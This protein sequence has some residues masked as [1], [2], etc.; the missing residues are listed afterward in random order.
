M[1]DDKSTWV[2]IEGPGPGDAGFLGRWL[3]AAVAADQ[4][5]EQQ[6][7][8][9]TSLKDQ[10]VRL[11]VVYTVAFSPPA[12]F[13]VR[14]LM[15]NL[16]CFS[17]DLWDECGNLFVVMAMLGFFRHTGNRYQ[18]T[19]PEDISGSKIETALLKLAA[20]EDE[21]HYLHPERLVSCLTK[22]ETKSAHSKLKRLPWMRRVADRNLL[23]SKAR[24]T[25]D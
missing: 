11:E 2:L 22:R 10:I 21:Q 1:N 19:I 25:G 23:L 16:S 7:K 20:T 8:R 12:T 18:M 6:F 13:F 3:L 5:L 14:L 4:G 15:N 24:P 17:L 9:N